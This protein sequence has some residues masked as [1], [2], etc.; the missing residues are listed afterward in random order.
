MNSIES[1]RRT[2]TGVVP[3]LLAV[4]PVIALLSLGACKKTSEADAADA[5][6]AAMT[7]G[8]ENIAIVT[9]GEVMSG[10]TLSGSLMPE[11]EA[12]VRA[13]VGG[14]VLQ[15]YAEQGQRV[16]A[17]QLLAQVDASGLQDAFLS[18]RAAVTS[19]KSSADIAARELARGEKLLAAGAIAER[20]IEQSRRASI[21]ANAGLADAR[22]RLANAQKQLSN[23]RITAPISGV[24]SDRQVSAGDV[25]QPGGAMF[26]VVDPSSMRL[27]ASIPAE[28]L[29]QVRIGVPVSFTVNGYPG[30]TLIGR[31]TRI[32][33]TA[34]PATRQVRIIA[35]IPNTSGTLVGGLFATGR[36][37]SESKSGLIAPVAA[38]DQ[39]SSVPSVMRIKQGKVERVPV[40]LGLRDEGAERIQIT[41]GVQA[42]DTLLLGAAQGISSGT[43]IKVSAPTDKAPESRS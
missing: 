36:L 14:S 2:G 37:A 29:D 22:A 9:L 32:N 34:D 38:I 18:A 7:I 10:P 28:Q 1:R 35:S 11:R 5:K 41:A 31:V 26:T 33:P 27:E 15:T 20:D 24:V 12:S 43:V 17:G 23:T 4:L 16:R 13:Q 40:Q 42:G 6:N 39:R 30:R 3:R 25:V 21:A 8:T 19:A